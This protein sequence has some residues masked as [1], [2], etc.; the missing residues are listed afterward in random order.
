M[1]PYRES[2]KPAEIAVYK[3]GWW[4]HTKRF[5]QSWFIKANEFSIKNPI[6]P[7]FPL[8]EPDARMKRRW[9]REERIRKEKLRQDVARFS[10]PNSLDDFLKDQQKFLYKY[11]NFKYKSQSKIITWNEST[12]AIP[13][14]PRNSS[15]EK[16]TG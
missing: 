2:A 6:W 12:N 5:C 3:H 16:E 4:M 10:R 15:D 1:S 9:E 13:V 8:Y 11:S 14:P 7:I